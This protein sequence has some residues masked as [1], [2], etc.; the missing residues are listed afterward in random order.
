[1]M[2]A[3]DPVEESDSEDFTSSIDPSFNPSVDHSDAARQAIE[4]A[5][6]AT[7]ARIHRSLW[8]RVYDKLVGL[9]GARRA[10]KHHAW[11]EADERRVASNLRLDGA[12][13]VDETMWDRAK[14]M[15]K[16]G[17]FDLKQETSTPD[18]LAA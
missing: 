11:T 7:E 14:L 8:S 16:R 18:D 3:E 9:L 2:M 10:E 1:M 13:T 15:M 5:K 4:K 6:T 17:Q 12:K